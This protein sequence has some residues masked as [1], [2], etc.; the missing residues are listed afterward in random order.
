MESVRHDALCVVQGQLLPSSPHLVP[1]L[2]LF[3]FLFPRLPPLMRLMITRYTRSMPRPSR[4]ITRRACTRCRE[5][6]RRA[7][8]EPFLLRI[9]RVN[10]STTCAAKRKRREKRTGGNVRSLYRSLAL[11][12]R[13]SATVVSHFY[14]TRCR[15]SP[16]FTSPSR[17][18]SSSSCPLAMRD[19]VHPS[20]WTPRSV[21]ALS[22]RL[23]SNTPYRVPT[24]VRA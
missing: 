11:A 18:I 16:T 5:K 23:P 4:G 1:L 19:Q 9:N 15:E 14:V 6:K 13:E 8:G 24:R 12:I 20:P 7:T 21:R 3:L 2:S 17:A 22:L 10:W